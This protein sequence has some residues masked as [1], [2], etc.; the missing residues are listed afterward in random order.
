[1]DWGD[2][3]ASSI[4][5]QRRTKR[6]AKTIQFQVRDWRIVITVMLPEAF[7]SIETQRVLP[8]RT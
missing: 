3:R 2:L 7:P 5:L 6:L 4:R 1:M 8:D